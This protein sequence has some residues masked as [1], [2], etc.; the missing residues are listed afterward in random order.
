M[1]A[2]DQARFAGIDLLQSYLDC[3]QSRSAARLWSK[4]L[5]PIARKLNPDSP[6][7]AGLL[8]GVVVE[9]TAAG[10][11]PLMNQDT[12]GHEETGRQV[13]KP[14]NRQRRAGCPVGHKPA[15]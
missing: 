14:I 15:N 8:P 1:V 6:A 10:I 5:I 9:M 2:L 13:L 11:E 7:L 4:T 3:G 12:R